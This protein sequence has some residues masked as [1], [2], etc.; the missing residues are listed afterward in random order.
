MDSHS[1]TNA[2]DKWR[3]TAGYFN[4]PASS[5]SQH[6]QPE[7][8]ANRTADSDHE[9]DV[10]ALFHPPFLPFF[11]PITTT[12]SLTL[13]FQLEDTSKLKLPSLDLSSA[14][15]LQYQHHPLTPGSKEQATPAHKLK[16]VRR[17]T[18]IDIL[19][20]LAKVG[21]MSHS[22]SSYTNKYTEKM[23]SLL[24]C[25]S[26]DSKASALPLALPLALEPGNTIKAKECKRLTAIDYLSKPL[27]AILD[28]DKPL[29]HRPISVVG[30][31]HSR[32]TGG[33]GC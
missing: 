21:R 29:P 18:A 12:H 22:L 1:K 25:V 23:D 31:V 2:K 26:R 9:L 30:S 11:L 8:P 19:E 4:K 27:S 14:P 3:L 7:N 10:R 33:C 16:E 20:A 32:V 5:S 15:T 13:Q 28:R 6:Q 24:P 17:I